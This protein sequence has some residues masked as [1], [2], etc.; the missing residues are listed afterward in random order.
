MSLREQDSKNRF[1]NRVQNYEAFRPGYP[2]EMVDFLQEVTGFGKASVF[3]DIGS[4]TGICAKLFLDRGNTVYA[5][6]PNREMRQAAEDSLG[7]HANFHSV[8]GSS[9]ITGV[10]PES[11]DIITVA[12]AFH[13][14]DPDP[15]KRE[16]LRIL[17]PG[18][19]V[20]L[21]W[22]NRRRQAE[23]F[24]GG[25]MD[26]VGRY[27]RKMT[28][29]SDENVMPRFF[30]DRTVHE[31]VFANPQAYDLERL[32][33]ELASYSYMPSEDDPDFAPMMSEVEALFDRYHEDGK[34]VVEYETR[35]YYCGMK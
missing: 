18:G 2:A 35:V 33:G 10:E 8:D 32:K 20:V 4:G 3:A 23:G 16:F 12:Q 22:N 26:I 19:F 30:G 6:E 1:S 24:M 15:T 14:F 31:K 25:Y 29:K 34:V 17:K 28:I 27:R 9:E 21:M 5:V 13:W 11:V 7:A